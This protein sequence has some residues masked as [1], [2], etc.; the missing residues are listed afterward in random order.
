MSDWMGSDL[1]P[2][3]V[4]FIM[5]AGLC[6]MIVLLVITWKDRK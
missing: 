4:G 1:I 6:Y 3:G 5:G 2:L